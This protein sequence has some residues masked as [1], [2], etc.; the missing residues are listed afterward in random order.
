MATLEFDRN[1]KSMSTIARR[2]NSGK[3][4]LLVKVV[5]TVPSLDCFSA[6]HHEI[7]AMYSSITQ[8]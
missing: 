6:L 8:G 7:A 1:R 5:L 4:I 2:G 3:N